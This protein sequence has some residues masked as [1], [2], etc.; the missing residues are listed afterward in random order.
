MCCFAPHINDEASLK[1]WHGTIWLVR[2]LMYL[3]HIIACVCRGQYKGNDILR[4]AVLK[5]AA[6][7]GAPY[8]DV[9]YLA[10]EFFFASKLPLCCSHCHAP[11]RT[12]P[13]KCYLCTVTQCRVV[14]RLHSEALTA[15]RRTHK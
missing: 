6:V 13:A 15:W 12:C 14:F 5:Y 4:L 11:E 7:L 8:V 3:R 10:A 2:M 1:P 9:E